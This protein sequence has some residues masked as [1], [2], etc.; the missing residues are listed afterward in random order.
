MV[1]DLLSL[2][3]L[4]YKGDKPELAPVRVLDPLAHAIK[5]LEFVAEEKQ[6]TVVNTLPE[7]LRAL[8]TS[9]GLH[10]VFRNLLENALTHS[11]QGGAIEVSV[12]LENGLLTFQVCDE[13]PGVPKSSRERIFERFYRLGG[14]TPSKSGSSGLGLAIC[15]HIVNG[16]GGKIWVESPAN[17][18]TSTGSAFFFTMRGA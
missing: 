15:R 5:L 6:V 10:E 18:E 7:D 4:D 3:K 14:K 1:R 2:S 8:G 17:P 13:G 16:F 9:D 11:P 12:T